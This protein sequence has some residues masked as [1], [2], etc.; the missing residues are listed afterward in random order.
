MIGSPSQFEETQQTEN[1]EQTISGFEFDMLLQYTAGAGVVVSLKSKL[2]GQKTLLIKSGSH[3][4][5]E[6]ECITSV[7]AV[8]P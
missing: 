2:H 7:K 8:Y 4:F 5:N 6:S 3:R 1:G